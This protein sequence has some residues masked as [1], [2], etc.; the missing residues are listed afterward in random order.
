MP[1]V[2]QQWSDPDG[3]QFQLALLMSPSNYTTE[4]ENYLGPVLFQPGESPFPL[5]APF[6]SQPS[7]GGPGGS[8]VEMVLS[9]S[10]TFRTV[11]GPGY[12]LVGWDQRGEYNTFYV[13]YVAF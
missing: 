13:Q 8:G 4:D 12:D 11:L 2:P 3:D 1:Q 7:T 6:S 5:L 9:R 10:S